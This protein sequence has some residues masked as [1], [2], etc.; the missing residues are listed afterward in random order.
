MN[1]YTSIEGIATFEG[2]GKSAANR[3]SS[4]SSQGTVN[5]ELRL[6]Q[7]LFLLPGKACPQSVAFTSVD[8]GSGVSTVAATAAINLAKHTT[9]RV[10]LVDGN[11]RRPSL[12]KRFGLSG[13]RG[14]AEAVLESGAI[15]EFVQSTQQRNLKVLTA[16]FHLSNP[17]SIFTAQGLKHRMV[18]LRSEFDHVL[19]DVPALHAHPDSMLLARIADGVVLVVE[20]GVTRRERAI[21]C[22]KMLNE[23]DVKVFGVILNKRDF[24]IPDFVYRKL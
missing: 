16:G 19:L 6:V 4:E 14:L 23:A 20:A 24:P 18:E 5:Q 21:K 13:L 1:S 12:D 15:T 7:S 11:L 22:K 2:A 17:S 8:Q 9:G 10:C 3:V